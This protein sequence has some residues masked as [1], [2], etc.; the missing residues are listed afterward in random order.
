[1]IRIITLSALIV[2]SGCGT[3]R[4]ITIKE[5]VKP[6]E[7]D[8]LAGQAMQFPQDNMQAFADDHIF[9]SKEASTGGSG[10]GGGGCGCN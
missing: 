9:F 3:V 2:L 5:D 10:V 4:N 8:V 1:M 6:W 7:K